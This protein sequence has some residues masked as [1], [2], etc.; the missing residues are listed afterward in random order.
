MPAHLQYRGKNIGMYDFDALQ[1]Q[2][3][4]GHARLVV[5]V[6]VT[7]HEMYSTLQKPERPWETRFSG[8]LGQ[9]HSHDHVCDLGLATMTWSQEASYPSSRLVQLGGAISFRDLDLLNDRRRGIDEPFE[10]SL[11]VETSI[12][13]AGGAEGGGM[14]RLS[15]AVPASEWRRMLQLVEH[16]RQVVVEVPVEGSGVPAAFAQAS[17]RLIKARGHLDLH[18]WEHAIGACRDV[19]EEL[20][21]IGGSF[22]DAIGWNDYAAR[23]TR[24]GWNLGQRFRAVRSLMRHAT[25]LGHHSDEADEP[26]RYRLEDAKYVVNLASVAFWYYVMRSR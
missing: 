14:Q 16:S 2:R 26:G 13:G 7:P 3:G 25:H 22:E 23:D 11:T 1:M 20:E 17:A 5:Q 6:K 15:H 12:L 4:V 10:F 19:F 9:G 18:Q 24:E 21:R 8:W